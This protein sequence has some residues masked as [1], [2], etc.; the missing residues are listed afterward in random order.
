VPPDWI[1]PDWP[2][3]AHVRALATTRLG[4]VSKAPYASFNL[5]D[6]VGDAPAAV[7]ANRAQLR[8]HL[9]AEPLWMQQVHGTRC[10][11]AALVPPGS[12]ADAAFTRT[13]GVVC[14]VLTA[15]CLPILLCDTAGTVVA[16][17]HAGWRGLAA[18]VIEATVSAM[19]VPGEQ[20]M[21]WLGPAIGPQHFEVGGEVRAA[22]LIQAT[23]AESAFL[24]QP[25]GKWLCDI[26]ALATQRLNALG[27]CRI[28]SAEFCTV[29]DSE[30]FFSYRRDG[31]SGRMASLIWLDNKVILC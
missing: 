31:A 7:T 20:L 13:P 4:G 25:N 1:A 9:P 24:A 29:R 6:H 10:I 12:A 14:A 19:G 2:A 22:F 21:A 5:G 28:A 16:A 15:D 17:A 3:P 23:Q 27:V 8:A 18:G 11:D 26:K 30:K